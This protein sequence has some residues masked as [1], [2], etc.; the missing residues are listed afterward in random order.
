MRLVIGAPL[1]FLDGA[2][3]GASIACSGCCLTAIELG[4][5]F[6]VVEVSAETLAHTTIAAWQRD[7][8]INLERS[9]RLGDELG[10]HLVSG[11]VDGL[12]TLTDTHDENGLHPP[13]LRSPL[14]PSPHHRS[15]RL[16]L[17]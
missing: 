4:P 12:A 17:R 15:Q 1:H 2:E 9:L 7:T 3:T 5:D 11:H 14:A 13:H 16:H 10:G 8:R 6:F